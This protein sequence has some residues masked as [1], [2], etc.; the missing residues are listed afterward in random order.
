MCPSSTLTDLMIT[1][2]NT[3]GS[4]YKVYALLGEV[5][6][7]GCPLGYLLLHSSDGESGGK[8]QFIMELLSHFNEK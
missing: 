3:N 7:S 6:G 8:E 2:G 1:S 4:N 5:Y